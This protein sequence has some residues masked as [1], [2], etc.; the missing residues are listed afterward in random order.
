MAEGRSWGGMGNIGLRGKR[1]GVLIATVG[2]V[3]DH[4]HGWVLLG[5]EFFRR[6][7]NT[8][9]LWNWDQY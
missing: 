2:A 9:S 6:L 5:C 3:I 8:G 7:F 4:P 1:E